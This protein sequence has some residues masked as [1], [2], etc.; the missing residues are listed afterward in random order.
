[1]GSKWKMDNLEILKKPTRKAT[2][3]G[4]GRVVSENADS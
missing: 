1:M 2:R 3:P 4:V